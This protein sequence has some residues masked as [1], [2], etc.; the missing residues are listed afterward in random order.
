MAAVLLDLP[1]DLLDRLQKMADQTGRT[2]DSYVLEALAEQIDHL[3]DRHF[4][5][6]QMKVSPATRVLNY[7]LDDIEREFGPAD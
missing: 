4:I 3:E 1:D 7:T 6:H 5:E 2:K